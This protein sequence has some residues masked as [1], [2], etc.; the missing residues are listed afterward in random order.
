M[1][2]DS[3][4]DSY[5]V[6]DFQV[7]LHCAVR[8]GSVWVSLIYLVLQKFLKDWIIKCFHRIWNVIFIW[9][10]LSFYLSIHTKYYHLS[11]SLYY[12]RVIFLA[13]SSHG[14]KVRTK[15]GNEF[16]NNLQFFLNSLI[17]RFIWI[18]ISNPQQIQF[19]EF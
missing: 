16:K 13:S 9:D 12:I 18:P 5:F 3:I 7:F 2:S 15:D 1:S 8:Y 17:H 6:S 19:D 11:F 4:L 14:M 10:P